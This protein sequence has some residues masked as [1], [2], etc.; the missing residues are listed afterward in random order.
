MYSVVVLIRV[1]K[2]LV[3]CES[4]SPGVHAQTNDHTEGRFHT[5]YK[6]S[7]RAWM[8]KARGLLHIAAVCTLKHLSMV[9]GGS[10]KISLHLLL[11]LKNITL[12]IVPK[13]ARHL[14]MAIDRAGSF[15]AALVLGWLQPTSTHVEEP[16]MLWCIREL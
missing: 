14:N 13:L 15:Q 10:R 2:P 5:S 8:Q 6:S 1:C 7:I 4:L 9:K 12:K 3:Y 16:S 11:F